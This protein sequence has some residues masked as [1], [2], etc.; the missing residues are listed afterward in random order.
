[1]DKKIIINDIHIQQVNRTRQSVENWRNAHKAAESIANPNRT[2]LYDL[3]DDIT[4]DGHLSGLITKRNS[5]VLNKV[6]EYY[7]PAGKKVDDMDKLIRT[8]AFRDLKQLILESSAYGLSGIEFIPGADFKFVPIPR[9]HIKPEFGVIALE[10]NGTTGIPY[11]DEPLVWIIDRKHLGYLLGCAPYVIYK[12][13]TIA[14]WARYIEI[15]GQ[16]VRIIKYDAHDEQTKIELKQ[17]LDESGSALA[18]MIPNQAQFEMMDGKQS[19]GT[20]ELQE[21]LKDSMN[22]EMSIIVVGNTETTTNG[23]TG[24]QAKSKVHQ[25]QQNEILK[26]D[27]DFL[28]TVLNDPRFFTVLKSYGYPVVEGGHFAFKTEVDI[29]KLADRIAI[30]K[31]VAALV[32]VADDYFYETY[33]IQKP[34]NYKELKAEQREKAKAQKKKKPGAPPDDEEDDNLQYR[35]TGR[36]RNLINAFKYFFD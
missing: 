30:D 24:S 3:Y 7:D 16:P 6:L 13:D 1:M 22:Q 18:L 26:N 20:G 33:G 35:N 23:K 31:E 5:A 32:P 27:M 36:L 10:Q 2:R 8:G 19:N 29:T 11:P 17:I 4:L 28:A 9:K 25:E 14:D 21:R 34:A 15:F 12:R